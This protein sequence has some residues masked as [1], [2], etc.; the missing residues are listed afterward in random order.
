MSAIARYHSIGKQGLLRG[1]AWLPSVAALAVQAAGRH[2]ARY[3]LVLALLWIGGMKFT[4]YEAEGISGVV[5]NSPLMSWAYSVVSVQGFSALLGI[6]ELAIALMIAS[7]P[8]SARA[9]FIG[10]GLAVGMFLTTLSF[11][12]TTPGVWE[13]SAGGF[14]ALSVV[15]GQFLAKDFVLFGASLRLFGDDWS[16]LAGK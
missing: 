14:P 3:G 8:F 9:A 1:L 15:P 2:T 5:S 4:A 10:S 12:L 6:T 16:A 11:L 13:A 7:R